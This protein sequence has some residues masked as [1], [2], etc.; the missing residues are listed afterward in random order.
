M[1]PRPDCTSLLAEHL[2]TPEEY[3]LAVEHIRGVAAA[4][5]AALE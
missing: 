1:S 2:K 4:I 5:G 3:A